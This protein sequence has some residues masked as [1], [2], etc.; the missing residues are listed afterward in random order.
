MGAHDSDG[1]KRAV[2]REG[3]AADIRATYPDNR[4]GR[5]AAERAVRKALGTD[6]EGTD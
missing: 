1:Y 5:R 3:I 2:E 6:S 4:E